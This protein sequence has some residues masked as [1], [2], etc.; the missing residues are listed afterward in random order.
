MDYQK[1]Q[2]GKETEYVIF[3]REAAYPGRIYRTEME[4]QH[5]YGVARRDLLVKY[6]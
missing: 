2:P 1:S 6:G 3:Q 4:L 5:R